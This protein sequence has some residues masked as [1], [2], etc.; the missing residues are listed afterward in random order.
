MRLVLLVDDFILLAVNLVVPPSHSNQNL[1]RSHSNLDTCQITLASL[2]NHRI[3][4]P[5][6]PRSMGPQS[7]PDTAIQIINN[8]IHDPLYS[9]VYAGG[10][11]GS[12]LWGAL[13]F[14]L[15]SRCRI[16]A[17]ACDIVKIRCSWSEMLSKCTWRGIGQRCFISVLPNWIY[18][19]SSWLPLEQ[20]SLWK[21]F[22]LP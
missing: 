16:L 5:T 14:H 15:G 7:L 1:Q 4:R 19:L 6:V 3:Y 21:E 22:Q 2:E 8:M 17:L 13:V 12:D 11:L 20:T 10:N 9:P 18:T